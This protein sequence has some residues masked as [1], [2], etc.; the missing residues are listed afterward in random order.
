M[1]KGFRF[2][3][4]A[5]ALAILLCQSSQ[6]FGYAAYNAW[7]NYNDGDYSSDEEADDYVHYQSNVAGDYFVIENGKSFAW[8]SGSADAANL[9]LRAYG[10]ALSTPTNTVFTDSWMESEV[11]NRFMVLPGTSGLKI[12]DTTTLELKIRLDGS[13]HGEATAYPGAGWAHAEMSAGLRIYDYSIVECEEGCSSPAQA[14][15]G[16]SSE[17]EAYDVYAP[18]WGYSYAAYWEESWKTSSNISDYTSSSDSWSETQNGDAMHYEAGH[19]FDTGM[20]TLGF[21]AIVGNPLDIEAYIYTYVNANHDAEAW[22]DFAN[23]FG[24]EVNPTVEGAQI[25]WGV[26]SQPVP[27]PG[28]LPLLGSGLLGLLG[29]RRR[30][31][32][33]RK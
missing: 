17:L 14:S 7:G 29:L 4:G 32:G 23:T 15:F 33:K 5:A 3:T 10:K 20:L 27:L 6:V 30:L 12:G 8:S 1:M 21:E 13:L 26:D 28:A 24:F 11:A 2:A 9:N 25:A 19:Y 18:Y 31:A 22:A 16:A